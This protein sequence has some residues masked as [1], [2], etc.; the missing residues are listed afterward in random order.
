MH[1]SPIGTLEIRTK[2]GLLCTVRKIQNTTAEESPDDLC[3]ET[4]RQLTAYFQRERRVFDLPLSFGPCTPFEQA[5]WNGLL[6]VPYGETVSYGQLA[7]HA[8]YPRAFR[9]AG[10]ANR[11]NP[12]AI[13]V[14]CHRCIASDGSLHGYFYGLEI[15]A[16]LLDLENPGWSSRRL[17]AG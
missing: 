4:A 13:I 1:P 15:K 5:V 2:D 8:G 9:A 14:P 3:E 6:A 7:L 16:F 11:K 17:R 10:M 12:L